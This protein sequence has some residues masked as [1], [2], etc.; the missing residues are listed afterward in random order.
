MVNPVLEAELSSKSICELEEDLFYVFWHYLR[1]KLHNEPKYVIRHLDHM[2]TIIDFM[3]KACERGECPPID[4]YEKR[5]AHQA[6]SLGWLLI[7][8]GNQIG[9]GKGTEPI[10]DPTTGNPLKYKGRPTTTLDWV[11]QY[12][13]VEANPIQDKWLT[14]DN[15]RRVLK[16]KADLLHVLTEARK[17]YNAYKPRNTTESNEKATIARNAAHKLATEALRPVYGLPI[18]RIPSIVKTE[19]KQALMFVLDKNK[20]PLEAV[21]PLVQR[22]AKEKLDKV[23]SADLVR[24]A[25][26]NDDEI[27]QPKPSSEPLITV[28]GLPSVRPPWG[29]V[30]GVVRKA[31]REHEQWKNEQRSLR[32]KKQ[33]A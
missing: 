19:A 32:C 27:K 13:R 16:W 7:G 22:L 17:L 2:T 8:R 4:T 6:R 1:D 3:R 26:S 33:S 12:L 24:Q 15:K 28:V 25:A 31:W 21:I 5:K 30:T 14:Q 29:G 10:I 18:E 11:H 23:V 20:S 9:Q